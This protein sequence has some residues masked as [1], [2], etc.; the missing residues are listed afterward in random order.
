MA[1]IKA[2]RGY[3]YNSQKVENIGAAMVPPYDTIS[4]EEQQE[5][6]SAHPHNIIR[7]SK[8]IT[9]EFDTEKNNCYTRAAS[10]LE[11]WIKEGILVRENKPVVYLYEQ[12]VRYNETT[13]VN[14]GIV[15]L[16]EL[17]ELEDS[18][19]MTCELP[20]VST[21]QD[22]YSLISAIN[23]NVDMINCMYMDPEKMLSSFITDLADTEPDMRFT[24]EEKVINTM[25]KSCS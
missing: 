13:F 2:F 22:R 12:R 14:H 8:G 16:L 17:S 5:Y 9:H 3:R 4:D 15:A 1:N 10:C 23:A 11:D 25:I 18:E 20:S 7:I 6:Y 24:T 21:T 19:V